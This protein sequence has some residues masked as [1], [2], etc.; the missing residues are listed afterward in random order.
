MS[1]ARNPKFVW[2]DEFTLRGPK[3]PATF[4]VGMAMS[5]KDNGDGQGFFASAEELSKMTPYTL[6]P[7][8]EAIKDL[9]ET[10]WVIRTKKG[11]RFGDRNVASEYR[12][13]I[14]AESQGVRSST[15]DES[16][17]AGSGSQGVESSTPLDPHSLDPLKAPCF[18]HGLIDCPGDEEE[19]LCSFHMPF[20]KD[21]CPACECLAEKDRDAEHALKKYGE[22]KLESFHLRGLAESEDPRAFV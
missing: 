8:K 1:E 9:I 4:R 7:V 21:S 22:Q 6:R 20:P 15:L 5:N 2:Q 19:E 16:L 12:L 11:G 13:S 18:C 10:K 17:G 14:P 3:K